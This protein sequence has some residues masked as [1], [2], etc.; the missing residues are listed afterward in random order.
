MIAV[1]GT[2]KRRLE[3]NRVVWDAAQICRGKHGRARIFTR[4]LREAYPVRIP[5]TTGL[6]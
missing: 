1:N 6:L 4:A 2:Y 5:L 3:Q